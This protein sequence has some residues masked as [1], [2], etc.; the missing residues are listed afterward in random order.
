LT[1]PPLYWSIEHGHRQWATLFILICGLLDKVDGLV[2]RVFDCRSAFGEVFD[3]ITDGICYGFG[4]I[5]VAAFGWA[6]VAPVVVV[7]GMGIANTT[8]RMVYAKR[9]G[10][11]TN[12]KSYAMER[13]VGYTGY[14][15]G[16][17][18]GGYEVSYYYWAFVPIVCVIVAHDAKRMLFDP[19]GGQ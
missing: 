14:L 10:R 7:I 11:A 9:A 16:F 6:P 8:M 1:L 2:A 18:T 19:I 17:A 13:L 4:L 15:I 12:Y 3:A 5:V